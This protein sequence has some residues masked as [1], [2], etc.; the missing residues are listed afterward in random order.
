VSDNLTPAERLYAQP[1]AGPLLQSHIDR[2]EQQ[3]IQA[4]EAAGAAIEARVMA[5]MRAERDRHQRLRDEDDGDLYVKAAEPPAVVEELAQI[6][7]EQRA[8]ADK[9]RAE[10]PPPAAEI[11]SDEPWASAGDTDAYAE[12]MR[13][14]AEDMRRA[15]REERASYG[16]KR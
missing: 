2:I 15:E 13:L 5:E 7:R 9:L 16:A 10:L 1:S 11:E 8:L 6:E 3:R 12:R 14:A 4:D